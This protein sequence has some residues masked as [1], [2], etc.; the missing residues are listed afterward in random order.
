MPSYLQ[1]KIHIYNWRVTHHEEYKAIGRK[2][3][4]KA[5]AWIKIKKVFLNILI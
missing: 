4:A 5:D 3:K 1:N 2:S